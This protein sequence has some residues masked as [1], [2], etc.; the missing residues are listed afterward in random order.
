VYEIATQGRPSGDSTRFPRGSGKTG[1]R[2]FTLIELL[3]VI[4]I[5]AVLIALLLPAVQAAREAARRS[6]CNNN[7]RQLGISLHNYEGSINCFPLATIVATW[8]GDTT[9]PAGN[10]RW[11]TLAYLTPFL[12]Q[13]SVFNSLNFSFPLYGQATSTPPSQVYPPNITA[14]NVM[15]SI[16][17]CPS[18][19]A[20][21]VITSDGFYGGTGRQFASMNYQFCSGS[22]ANGGDTSVSGD[23][24]FRINTIARVQD[25]TD[26][27]SNTA[28]AGESLI[29]SGGVRSY[30]PNAVAW[31]P[32]L[33]YS[34][35]A[36]NST[37]TNTITTAACNAPIAIGPNRMSVWV[38]GNLSQGMYNHALPPN[39]P[40]M[41]C[42]ITFNSISYG[43]KAARS[44]HP[45]GANT[46]FGDGSVRFAK[47]TTDAAV[48]AAVGSRAGGEIANLQ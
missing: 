27:L 22:G 24:V 29:G 20:E 43:W 23:G 47:N 13:T 37:P 44:R 5:I 36:W 33:V 10:Y 14:V 40:M 18:D 15:V 46:L 17:L 25:V 38:D 21:R 48:W 7:L 34:S 28:F 2:G 12:E 8:P 32:N 31:D 3:V 4:A 6:Q 39:S 1:G 35:V 9:L 45:G 26:G 41:D 11:G 30:A 19:R 16:F 42:L